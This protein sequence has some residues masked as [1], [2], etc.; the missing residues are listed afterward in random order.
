MGTKQ[1]SRVVPFS[2]TK[3]K[4]CRGRKGEEEEEEEEEEEGREGLMESQVKKV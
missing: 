4:S 3:L 1:A 2:A